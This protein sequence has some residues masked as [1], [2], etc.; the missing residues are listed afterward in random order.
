[1][2]IR[3]LLEQTKNA[4]FN[5]LREQVEKLDLYGIMI[6]QVLDFADWLVEDYA[7]WCREEA[8]KKSREKPYLGKSY[9]SKLFANCI[10]DTAKEVEKEIRNHIITVYESAK[11]LFDIFYDYELPSEIIQRYFEKTEE[12]V[13]EALKTYVQNALSTT[14]K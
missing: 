7:K 2:S 5:K 11:T 4:C 3:V 9:F 6:L 8:E 14:A 10:Y 12:I 1:M 13:R